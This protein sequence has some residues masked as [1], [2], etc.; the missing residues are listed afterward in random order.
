MAGK[1]I[2]HTAPLTDEKYLLNF[3][4]RYNLIIIGYN[5]FKFATIMTIANFGSS[6]N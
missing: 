3:F 5:Y 1:I 4:A 2:S 6:S